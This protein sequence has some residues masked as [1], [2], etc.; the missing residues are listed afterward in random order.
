MDKRDLTDDH[1]VAVVYHNPYDN[2]SELAHLFF[3][4]CFNAKINPYA[5]TIMVVGIHLCHMG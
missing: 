4:R 3:Q 5:V 2:V 1:N